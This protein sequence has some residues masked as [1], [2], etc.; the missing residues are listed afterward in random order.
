MIFFIRK[1]I[2]T[3][4]RHCNRK[5]FYLCTITKNSKHI[6]IVREVRRNIAKQVDR[7]W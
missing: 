7:N 3:S 6:R 5:Q 4:T 2:G 1:Q